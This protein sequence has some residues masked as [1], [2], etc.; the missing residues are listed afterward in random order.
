MNLAL[1]TWNYF[2]PVITKFG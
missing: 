2:C 1:F